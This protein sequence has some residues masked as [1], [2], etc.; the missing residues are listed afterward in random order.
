MR[1]R[2]IEIDDDTAQE[3]DALLVRMTEWEI[4]VARAYF[5]TGEI[6]A[7]V[8]LLTSIGCTTTAGNRPTQANIKIAMAKDDT[9]LLLGLLRRAIAR[10]TIRDAV[11]AEHQYAKLLERCMDVEPVFDREGVFTGVMK[12]DPANA[13]RAVENVVK[14][15]GLAASDKQAE[16][17]G[18]A[19]AAL[20][21]ILHRIDQAGRGT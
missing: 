18:G 11:W 12:F 19:L 8:K 15:K 2:D 3:I 5:K 17:D 7:A 6:G 1:I 10:H 21:G 14:L 20:S 9:R 13:L 4:Q 16:K